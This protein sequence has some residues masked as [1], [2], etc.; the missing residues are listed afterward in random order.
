VILLA[1]AAAAFARV[2]DLVAAGLLGLV[3]G[4]TEFIPVSSTGHL[5]LAGEF[6]GFVGERAKTFE[7]VI[8]LGAIL[9][10][11][12]LYLRRLVG[13]VGAVRR[14]PRALR[15]V[16]NLLVAFLPVALVGLVAHHWITDH[17][18]RPIVVA[19][20]LVVGGVIILLVERFHPR[21]S[22]TEVDDLP[23]AT[24]GGIGLAQVLSLVP[25]TSRSG[26]TI[27]GGY[28]LGL[29]RAAA[30]EFSFLLAIP[31][32]LAATGYELLKSWSTLSAADVPVFAVGFV[33]AFLSAIVVVRVFLTYV[34]RHSFAVFAWYRILFGGLLLAWFLRA[35]A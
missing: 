27:M 28:A 26:A 33:T 25:G 12:L 14:E 6:L 21:P 35:G 8:Q 13:L 4:A 20:S 23:V 22:V 16:I 9:A 32:M 18:F 3:E 10:I 2:N 1:A 29:S 17:L 31:V 19:T 7:I 30:T 24:A 15:L 5:I 11:T 34:A